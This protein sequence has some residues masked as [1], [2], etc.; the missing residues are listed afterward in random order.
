LSTESVYLLRYP[1]TTSRMDY[2]EDMR[3]LESIHQY[4][5]ILRQGHPENKLDCIK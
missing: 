5:Q 2:T 3:R 4:F 1:S